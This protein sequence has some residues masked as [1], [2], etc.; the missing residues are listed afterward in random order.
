MRKKR[1]RE[2]RKEIEKETEEIDIKTKKRQ[3]FR[4]GEE[5]AIRGKINEIYNYSIS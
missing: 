3:D 4:L 2:R 5:G 1:K